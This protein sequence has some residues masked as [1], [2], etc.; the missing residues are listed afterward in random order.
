LKRRTLSQP[1]DTE[2][3]NDAQNRPSYRRLEIR[4]LGSN[5]VVERN[6]PFG[7]ADQKP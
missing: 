1:F 5:G 3:I 4:I 2:T 6:I 7:E